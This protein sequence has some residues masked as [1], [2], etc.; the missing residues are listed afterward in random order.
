MLDSEGVRIDENDSGFHIRSGFGDRH[1]IVV[2]EA[3]GNDTINRVQYDFKF[4]RTPDPKIHWKA[5]EKFQLGSRNAIGLHRD[6]LE[7]LKEFKVWIPNE[8][9]SHLSFEVVK[10][11][12]FV[13]GLKG[14]PIS[15]ENSNFLPDA[16]IDSLNQLGDTILLSMT[17]SIRGADQ[18]T[19]QIGTSTTLIK[20][21]GEA[22][23]Y[24]LDH[25][26]FLKNYADTI[27][28][29][30]EQLFSD[31]TVKIHNPGRLY[32]K[33][34]RLEEDYYFKWDNGISYSFDIPYELV[35]AGDGFFLHDLYGSEGKY[36]LKLKRSLKTKPIDL[37]SGR[38]VDPH[39]VMKHFVIT[40]P[41]P[42]K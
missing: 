18:I 41:D 8:H 10:A 23:A 20:L 5:M 31:D 4:M 14:P 2:G 16:F 38:Y 35:K 7:Y 1:Y 19:R 36:Q 28:L 12:M 42:L 37:E 3:R 39:F 21:D 40:Y 15:F 22:Y 25:H 29:T 33:L 30:K 32:I 13:S 27:T 6:S 24:H 11:S 17:A 26:Y 9:L 34:P